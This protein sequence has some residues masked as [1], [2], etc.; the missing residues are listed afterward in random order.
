MFRL[1][2]RKGICPEEF[3]SHAEKDPATH[4]GRCQACGLSVYT[5]RDDLEEGRQLV[6]GMAKKRVVVGTLPEGSGKMMPTPSPTW[7]THRTWWVRPG[8]NAASLFVFA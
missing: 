8:L 4:G 2:G 5:D 3:R 7:K 6:P 1:V